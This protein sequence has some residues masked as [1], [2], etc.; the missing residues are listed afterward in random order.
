MLILLGKRAI[1]LLALYLNNPQNNKDAVFQQLKEWLSDPVAGQN[2]TLVLIAA[3]LY[4]HEDNHKDAYRVLK[5]GNGL[6]Q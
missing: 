5:E 6:E 2:K 3:T 4:L 1:K